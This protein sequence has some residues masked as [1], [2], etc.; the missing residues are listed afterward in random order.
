MKLHNRMM[1][2][3]EARAE[4][5]KLVAEWAEKHDL[6]YGELVSVMSEQLQSIAKYMIR[7]ERH[8][9]DPEMPGDV[10]E[11]EDRT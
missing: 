2:V 5:G 8:P 10:A 4:F 11:T 1:L 7:E 3:Q 9:D 6:T